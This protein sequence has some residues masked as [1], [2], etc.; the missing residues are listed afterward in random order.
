M[1]MSDDDD[2]GYMRPPKKNRFKPGQSGNPKGRPLK[3]RHA[4]VPSQRRKD[5]LAVAET[6]MEMR[7]PA[8]MRKVTISEAVIFS[9]VTNAMKGKPAYTKLWLEM[10]QWAIDERSRNHPTI[11]VIEM[12]QN[13]AEDARAEP[14]KAVLEA[15]DVHIEMMKGRY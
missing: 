15:V 7:T 5:I 12:F 4:L 14:D 13:M 10:E 1:R 2:V 8:G 9:I 6:M 11:A 3:R